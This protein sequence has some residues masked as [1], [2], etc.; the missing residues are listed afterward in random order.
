[1]SLIDDL[2][3]LSKVGNSL[4]EIEVLALVRA[5]TTKHL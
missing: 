2:T 3:P 4:F 5:N 1:M